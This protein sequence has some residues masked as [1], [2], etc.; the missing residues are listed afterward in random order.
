MLNKI[1]DKIISISSGII[2]LDGESGSGKTTLAKKIKEEFKNDITVVSTDSFLP[3]N[4]K[5]KYPPIRLNVDNLLS[6]LNDYL[7]GLENVSYIE[8]D[9]KL[10][11][12]TTKQIKRTRYL[13]IEGCYSISKYFIDYY[14]LTF[15]LESPSN[16]EERRDAKGNDFNQRYHLL[17]ESDWLEYTKN[18]NPKSKADVVI[19]YENN[20]E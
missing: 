6:F 20:K 12:D 18:E 2:A 16:I 11:M 7:K 14:D 4:T 17:W 10:N 19:N 1:I 3:G 13:L 5:L 9:C 15:F 8:Y